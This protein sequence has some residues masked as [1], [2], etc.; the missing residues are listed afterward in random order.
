[1]AV[2]RWHGFRRPKDDDLPDGWTA[3]QLREMATFRAGGRLSLTMSDYVAEGIPAYSA[4]GRNGYT[5]VKEFDGPAVIVSSIGERWGKCFLAEG[6]FTTLANIQVIFP[7]LAQIDPSYL[8]NLVNDEGFW[9]RAQTAQPYIRP[10]DIKKAWIPLPPEKELKRMSDAFRACDAAIDILQTELAAARRLKT[11]LMQ[12]LFTKGIPGRHRKFKET[13]WLKFP[14][15]WNVETLRELAEIEAGFTMGRDLSRQDTVTIPYVT[16]VNVQDGSFDLDDISSI[17]IKRAELETGTLRTGDVLMT[18]GGDRDKLG[19]GAIWAGQIEPCAY[20]NHIFRV[21]FFP[22]SY[23]PKLFHYLIQSYQARRYFAS[24]AKQTSNLCSINSREL[25]RFPVAV[26][27]LDEQG[28]MVELLDTSEAN[29][30]AI[31]SKLTALLRLKKSLLQNL[32]TGKVRVT[33]GGGA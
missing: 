2:N 25:K 15:T 14:K 31:H 19:R 21:R 7:D 22:D 30:V 28:E 29:I 16:V 13:K 9:P 4:E 3:K 11:A 10:S 27:D 1:M 6:P 20:Q 32:L 23:Q 12:Q 8:W 24:H 5:T 18:E 26:P 17:E 33:T